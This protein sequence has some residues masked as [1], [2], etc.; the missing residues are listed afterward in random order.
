MKYLSIV[1]Y[2]STH[3]KKLEG[4][5]KPKMISHNSKFYVDDNAGA[6]SHQ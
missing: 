4:L 5:M 1:G 2:V 3:R 6:A